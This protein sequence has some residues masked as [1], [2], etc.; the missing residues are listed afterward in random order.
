M[1]ATYV[2]SADFYIGADG[3]MEA[4]DGL[5]ELL[6]LIVRDDDSRVFDLIEMIYEETGDAELV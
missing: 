1:M 2:F 5:L 3:E 6:G 4:R